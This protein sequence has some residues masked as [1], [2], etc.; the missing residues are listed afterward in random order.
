M[1]DKEFKRLQKKVQRN[2]RKAW[3]WAVGKEQKDKKGK[4]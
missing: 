2:P 4:K 1:N 3:D